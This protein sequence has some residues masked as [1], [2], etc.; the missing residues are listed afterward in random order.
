[1]IVPWN[2][3]RH[4]EDK[5]RADIIVISPAKAGRT[6]LCVM[7][8]KYLSLRYGV[9]FSVEDLHAH[10]AAIPSILYDHWLWMHLRFAT[11]RQRLRGRYIIPRRVLNGNKLVL[12]VR[13]PRDIVVS[14]YF[15]ET[16]RVNK[17]KETLM[18][19]KEY[20]RDRKRGI[21]SVVRVLNLTYRKTCVCP[22]TLMTKYESFKADPVGELKR[23]LEFMEIPI[24]ES[25]IEE[26]VGFATFDNMKKMEL[27][28]EFHSTRLRPKD[29]NDP[30]SFKVR[31]GKV[32]GYREY[33]DEHDLAYLECQAAKLHPVFGYTRRG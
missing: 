32:G 13:D 12:L 26:A 8:N 18:P 23:V 21:S 10:D 4:L 22:R 1:M 24:D 30:D 31:K 6:W 9:P 3:S 27:N 29:P 33:F 7:I 5:Q 16:K 25:L 20:I 28:D 2:L 19:M 15:Q 11:F 17:H 14:A